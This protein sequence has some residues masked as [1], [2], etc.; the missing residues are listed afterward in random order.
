[1]TGM[2]D[3]NHFLIEGTEFGKEWEALLEELRGVE[4]A[5]EWLEELEVVHRGEGD[6]GKG[7]LK[8]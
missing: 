8:E 6:V 5:G 4:G 2:E 1:M 7:G 3:V